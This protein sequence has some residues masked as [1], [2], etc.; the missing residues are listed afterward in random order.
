MSANAALGVRNATA[1]L[2]STVPPRACLHYVRTWLDAPGGI[3]TAAAA[4]RAA[5]HKHPGDRNPP[6]G[7]PV[8]FAPNHVALSIGGGNII[9]TDWPHL[10][11]VG[12]T[13]INTLEATWHHTYLGWSEDIENQMIAGIGAPGT[14]TDGGITDVGLHVPN[15]LGGLTDLINAMQDVA[16]AG[17]FLADPRTWIRVAMW[18][19]GIA[20]LWIAVAALAKGSPQGA[21]RA[22]VGTAKK[23]TRTITEAGT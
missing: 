22:G 20:C 14:L 10:S 21:V 5:K 4:W 7:V 18:F 2:G 19:A 9:S 3:L 6:A 1:A 13:T 12:R 16:K 11:N 17:A 23:V 8:F 15:P